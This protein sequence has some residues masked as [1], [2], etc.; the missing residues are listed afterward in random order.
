MVIPGNNELITKTIEGDL[1]T[2]KEVI[3]ITKD[4]ISVHNVDE[5][6]RNLEINTYYEKYAKQY[7]VIQML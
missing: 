4:K 3:D 7:K 5:K 6:E 2:N 1:P